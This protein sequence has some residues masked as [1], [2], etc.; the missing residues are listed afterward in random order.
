[1]QHLYVIYTIFLLLKRVVFYMNMK[2]N[3]RNTILTVVL[4]SFCLL[5]AINLTSSI[6]IDKDIN[7]YNDEVVVSDFTTEEIKISDP[8]LIDTSKMNMNFESLVFEIFGY[9]LIADDPNPIDSDEFGQITLIQGENQKNSL[10]IELKLESRDYSFSDI[11]VK[12]ESYIDLYNNQIYTYNIENP[13]LGFFMDINIFPKLTKISLAFDGGDRQLCYEGLLNKGFS[14]YNAYLTSEISAYSVE[15][16]DACLN[17]KSDLPFIEQKEEMMSDHLSNVEI[18]SNLDGINQSQPKS[19]SI[20][21]TKYGLVHN[22]CFYQE[23]LGYITEDSYDIKS[24]M[25]SYTQIQ[26]VI[27]RNEPSE[28]QVKSDLQ[29]Y[30]KDYVDF[31]HNRGYMRN[32]LAYTIYAHGFITG[33]D[34]QI[35]DK[36]HPWIR[37]TGGEV[38]DLWYYD[39]AGYYEIDVHPWD[40]IILA[41]SCWG[42]WNY[43]MAEAFVDYGADAFC[44]VRVPDLASSTMDL[45][46]SVT[47]Y[48]GFWGSLC[49]NNYNVRTSSQH[50]VANRNH[51]MIPGGWA[52]WVYGDHFRVYGNQYATLA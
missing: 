24:E 8:E 25:L 36:W 28:S 35:G 12:G 2:K 32:V 14:T 34:W 18:I 20:T 15:S 22:V 51:L 3:Y 45:K 47:G 6:N 4:I 9:S 5:S 19:A 50:L 17:P 27:E 16:K 41:K 10:N 38:E 7:T 11:C 31:G 49:R 39:T 48:R 33:S 42:L 23:G 13:R 43:A 30:N 37:L 1:M 29:Y 40:M 26:Y 52:P 44:G 21:T 46:L